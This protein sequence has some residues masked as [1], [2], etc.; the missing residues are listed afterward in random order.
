MVKM[1]YKVNRIDMVQKVK[2]SIK[3]NRLNRVD[4][5]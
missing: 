3:D 5:V 4:R 1:V 2:W